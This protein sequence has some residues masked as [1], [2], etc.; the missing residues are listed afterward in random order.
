M[1]T[2]RAALRLSGF[3]MLWY[4]AAYVLLPVAPVRAGLDES[5]RALLTWAIQHHRQFGTEVIFT[6]GP[7]GFLLEPRGTIAAYPWQVAGRLVFAAAAAGGIGLLGASWIRSAPARWIWAMVI[8]V[9]AEP[10][11]LMPVLLF[12]VT[13]R[14]G[15]DFRWK[16]TVVLLLALAAGLTACAKFTGFMLLIALLPLLAIRKSYAWTAAAAVGS[17][18]VSWL[19]AGQAISHLPAFVRGSMEITSGYST[20]MVAGLPLIVLPMALCICGL[21]VIHFARQA[22]PL[23]GWEALLS[24]G[25]LAACEFMIFRH[26]LIRADPPHFYMAFVNTA[27]PIAILL[28]ALPDAAM[29]HAGPRWRATYSG[30]VVG[31]LL[32][33][34]LYSLSAADERWGLFVESLRLYPAYARQVFSSAAPPP[35]PA[36]DTDTVDVFPDEL[37]YALAKGLALRNRPVI[38]A[39]STYTRN[40]CEKNA[41]FLD[42]PNAPRTIYFHSYTIDNRYPTLDDS[43]AWR[44]LLTRYAPSSVADGYLLL[45]RRDRPEAYRTVP[46]LSRRIR[47]DEFV[48]I[49]AAPGT[50]VWAELDMQRTLAGRVLDLL[51]RKDKM[52][53]RVETSRGAGDFTLLD[54][55]AS[56]GF[57]LSPYVNS[58]ESMRQLYEPEAARAS[59]ANVLRIAIHRS[60]ASAIGYA[61]TVGIRLYRL[62]VG[63]PD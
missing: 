31:S 24:F 52:A 10:A 19:A 30:L 38:Q 23:R 55:T 18:L 54:E 61:P 13:M 46:I 49:P 12:L 62:M 50:L 42:G 51:Y 44:S 53:L 59:A 43:L 27:I 1:Q 14:A 22:P 37:S 36:A 28:V 34:L 6:Y 29:T 11:T 9:L 25:W 57:L 15:D 39:Y 47:T 4:L 56:G 48:D 21:P 20:A 16:R 26:G 60:R 33:A 45:R 40:L 3:L 41:A 7:W 5:W 63:P 17:F 8:V 58:V 2:S 32:V 35:A